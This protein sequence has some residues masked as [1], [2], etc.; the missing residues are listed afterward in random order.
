MV[1]AKA[2]VTK[3]LTLGIKFKRDL[4]NSITKR[5]SFYC[6]KH[7]NILYVKINKA[8]RL[9]HF[10]VYSSVTL[11]TLTMSSYRHHHCLFPPN[12]KLLR[13]NVLTQ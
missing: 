6:V 11:S 12:N 7:T 3:V 1:M 8:Y 2:R 4:K 10:K 9:N 5:N 13:Y